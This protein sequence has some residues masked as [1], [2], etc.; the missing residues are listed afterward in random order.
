[1]KVLING[2]VYDSAKTPIL[3]VFNGDEQ[4]IFGPYGMKRFVSAPADSTVE[5]RQ[6]LIDTELGEG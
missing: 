3:V 2:K 4:Q 6:K 5:E 1:M